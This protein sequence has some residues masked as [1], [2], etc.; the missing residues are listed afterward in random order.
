MSEKRSAK[1]AEGLCNTPTALRALPTG[2]STAAAS[3]TPCYGRWSCLVPTALTCKRGEDVELI[4]HFLSEAGVQEEF[5]FAL[6]CG[7]SDC[8]CYGWPG[9]ALQLVQTLRRALL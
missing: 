2:P 5:P 3:S 7:T 8:A 4:L 1:V 6:T 9:N